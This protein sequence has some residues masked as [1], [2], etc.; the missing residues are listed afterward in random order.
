M[1]EIHKLVMST[2]ILESD[3]EIAWMKHAKCR[4]MDTNLFYPNRSEKMD[5]RVKIACAACPVRLECLEYG[6]KERELS[7]GT[8]GGYAGQQLA[9]ARIMA[10]RGAT[11]SEIA[12]KL[13]MGNAS[14]LF[15]Y[16]PSRKANL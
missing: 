3:K 2:R 4:G 16:R 11:T 5:L 14:E 1:L 13:A 7:G 6:I 15:K 12:E 10:R 9:R 8:Y